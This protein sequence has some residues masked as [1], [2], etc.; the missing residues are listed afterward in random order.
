MRLLLIGVLVACAPS[1]DVSRLVGARCDSSEECDDRCLPD[2]AGYPGGL[3][4]VVCNRDAECV[5]ETSCVDREGGA[6]LFTCTGDASCA[7]LGEGWRCH[8]ESL[9]EDTAQK[10]MVCRGD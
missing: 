1:S 8:E 5:D 3:C 9:R 6:C 7:F 2:G 4:T 10:V